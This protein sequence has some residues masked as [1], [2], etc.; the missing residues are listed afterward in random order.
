MKKLLLI[1]LLIVGCEETV[2]GSNNVHELT[3]LDFTIDGK[4]VS[5]TA[6]K[7]WGNVTNI[8]ANKV[9]SPWYIEGMFY[10]DSTYTYVFG[11]DNVW[12]GLSI[13]CIKN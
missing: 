12:M 2:I 3:N 6:L 10:S 8:G 13:R 1:A 5:N 7:V 9:S 4:S 11:G